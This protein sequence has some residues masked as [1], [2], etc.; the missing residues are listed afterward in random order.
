MKAAIT[1]AKLQRSEEFRIVHHIQAVEHIESLILS[2][3]EGIAHKAGD[4]AVLID[5][6]ERVR[7]DEVLVLCV[8]DDSGGEGV[9]RREARDLVRLG[10]QS[11]FLKATSLNML[12]YIHFNFE[13]EK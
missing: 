1:H 4:G 11:P 3:D 12:C 9:E 5:I 13:F 8:S 7:R 6:V 10:V 2:Q